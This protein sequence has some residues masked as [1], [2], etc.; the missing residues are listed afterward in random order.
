MENY[1]KVM[2][3]VKH[4]DDD[5]AQKWFTAVR[6]AAAEPVPGSVDDLL[7]AFRGKAE[8]QGFQSTDIDAFVEK[9]KAFESAYDGMVEL[10][11][12]TPSENATECGKLFAEQAAKAAPTAPVELWKWDAAAKEWSYRKDAKS[13]FE[14]QVAVDANGVVYSKLGEDKKDWVAVGSTN[15]DT[16]GDQLWQWDDKAEE[17]SYRK[18][19][20]DAYERQV[21]VDA[22]GVVYSKLGK[23]QK[24]WVSVTP[25]APKT[26]QQDPA[27]VADPV[28]QKTVTEQSL[29][30]VARDLE[31]TKEELI[32]VVETITP[33]EIEAAIAGT[34]APVG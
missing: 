30:E 1:Q 22:N 4:P 24:T 23:D 31:L 25:P 29:V 11:K 8:A 13:P 19:A 3:M 6:D 18:T 7:V 26:E 28:V 5:T 33:E 12:K 21:A 15:T 9:A 27:P 2:L 20:T 14:R 10:A 32:A 16:G 34:P 17:W